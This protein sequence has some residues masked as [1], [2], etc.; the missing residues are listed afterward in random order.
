MSSTYEA[1]ILVPF[2]L[3]PVGWFPEN[4]NDLPY[5][6][7]ELDL[8]EIVKYWKKNNIS[9]HGITITKSSPGV[10]YN[11]SIIERTGIYEYFIIEDSKTQG[12]EPLLSHTPVEC[13][14]PGTGYVNNLTGEFVFQTVQLQTSSKNAPISFTAFRNNKSLSGFTKTN[15]LGTKFSA[16]FEFA[17]KLETY[18]ALLV[19]PN[20][21]ESIFTK[22]SRFEAESFGIFE[23]V[24]DIYVDLSS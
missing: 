6:V 12:L 15:F 7:V 10:I 1:G 19:H 17:L 9:V 16:N 11:P 3:V 18:Y 20:G 5:K 14:F 8:T 13:G 22:M 4:P 24:S 21:S 23:P 2:S